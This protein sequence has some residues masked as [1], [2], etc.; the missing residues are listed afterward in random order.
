[1]YIDVKD[2]LDLVDIILYVH[3]KLIHYVTIIQ[4]V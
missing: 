2:I 3:I 4:K 1:M